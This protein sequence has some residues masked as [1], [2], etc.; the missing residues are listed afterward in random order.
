MTF[1]ILEY[2][3]IYTKTLQYKQNKKYLFFTIVNYTKLIVFQKLSRTMSTNS[4]LFNI[5]RSNN[6]LS[7]MYPLMFKQ[8]RGGSILFSAFTTSHFK[9]NTAVFCQ[10]VSIQTRL[11]SVLHFT[12]IARKSFSPLSRFKCL[13]MCLSKVG[14]NG[15]V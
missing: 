13:R 15:N 9:I 4:T 2:V 7:M 11:V 10:Y 12:L 14:F 6:K 3:L 1:D 5:F 8:I